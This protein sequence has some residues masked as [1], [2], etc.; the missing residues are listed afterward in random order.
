MLLLWLCHGNNGNKNYIIKQFLILSFSEVVWW[1]DTCCERSLKNKMI[2]CIAKYDTLLQLQ[3]KAKMLCFLKTFSFL[4]S[5]QG[6]G[7]LCKIVF[8]LQWEI[9]VRRKC[10]DG[11][12]LTTS[13]RK[14]FPN[15][16]AK[17]RDLEGI[18]CHE[19]WGKIYTHIF[20]LTVITL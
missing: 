12:F 20:D 14:F 11:F 6:N 18:F 15:H 17:P 3:D 7:K 4:F 8:I 19:W 1:I 5:L 2:N 10:E 13:N 16:E 9:T